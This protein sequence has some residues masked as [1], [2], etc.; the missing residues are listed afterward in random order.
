[1]TKKNDKHDRRVKR[2]I[3]GTGLFTVL[4]A[5]ST[6]AW[7]I[8]MQT[9][10]VSPFDV[11]VAAIDGLS[12]SLDG[13]SFSDSVTINK[14]N[15]D[16]YDGNTNT[17]GG[18][19]LKPISTLGKMNPDTSK[20]ILYES[21]SIDPTQAGGGYRL[22]SSVIEN[23]DE[24]RSGYVAFD[25]FIKN[26]SGDE[27]YTE[28]DERNEEA[29]FL[30]P[31]SMVTVGSAGVENT[32]IENSVRV[33]FAQIG[34]VISTATAEQM[35]AI[36]CQEAEGVTTIC[37]KRDAV[38]WE[39]NDTD[40][41]ENAINWYD[42]VCKAR[43]GKAIDDSASY[44]DACG[45]IEDGTYYPTYVVGGTINYTD[46][47]NVYDGAEYNGYTA[48]IAADTPTNGKLYKL[49]YFTDTEKN[50]RGNDRPQF[51]SL[52]PN[53]VTKVRIYIYL[54]GQDVDNY[55]FASL[56]KQIAVNFSLSKERYFD[57]DV[58]YD[59][60]GTATL[61]DDVIYDNHKDPSN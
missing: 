45:T 24:E 13:T 36:S 27:Y 33:A 7:F 11:T 29:V 53:S 55:D 60:S 57:Q 58:N 2:F 54:E 59:P 28:Y 9:V 34:R 14:D 56:G 26:L 37:D 38:I 17:W 1:M 6:Y 30:S 5:T 21:S 35:Q 4:L 51:I 46:E 20:L 61:P 25:L 32:G 16:T 19:G 18:K 41:V 31:D 22:M 43:T 48:S 39:P 49:D 52:A 42:N 8:G 10:N 44:G 12:L 50:L 40:H 47:V 23:T 3:V 15:F